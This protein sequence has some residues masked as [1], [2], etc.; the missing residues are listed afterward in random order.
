MKKI[1]F[2]LFLLI[3]L[4]TSS[5]GLSSFLLEGN[6]ITKEIDI[7]KNYN[8]LIE[9]Y[10]NNE[11]EP[12]AKFD[13]LEEA[14]NNANLYASVNTEV[15]VY[16]KPGLNEVNVLEVDQNIT[17]NDNVN[18][19][20][21]F[22]DKKRV[23]E[24]IDIIAGFSNKF[25]DQDANLVNSNRKILLNLKNGADLLVDKGANLYLGGE[26]KTKGVSNRYCEILLSKDSS[27]TVNG[28]FY[29]YGYVKEENTGE[30]TGIDNEYD[31][32]RFIHITNGGT[33]YTPFALYDFVESGGTLTEMSDNGVCPVNII[34]MPSMQTYTRIDYGSELI[35]SC[36]VT[37]AGQTLSRDATIISSSDKEPSLF[38][39]KSGYI[40]IEHT[41]LNKNGYT[42]NDNSPTYFYVN[43]NI[44]LGYLK[45]T[46]AGYGIDTRTCFL[47]ISNKFKIY[48]LS[49]SYFEMSYN[50]KF[51][52]GSLL[53]I[54]DNAELI[55]NADLIFL[56]KDSLNG[57]ANAGYIANQDGAL[58]Q[59]AGKITINE[60]GKIGANI[61]NSS[62]DDKAIIDF[63]NLSS[64]SG[65]TVDC[66]NGSKFVRISITSD[67]LFLNE[68]GE[69]VKKQ[70]LYG[71]NY[72][73]SHN[74]EGYFW[75]GSAY[76]IL[77][78][79]ITVKD[80]Y[81]INIGQFSL[82]T[83]PNADGSDATLLADSQSKSGTFDIA[84]GNYFRIDS[85]RRNKDIYFENRIDSFSSNFWFKITSNVNVIIVPNKG[86]NLSLITQ[87]A[88]GAS[89]AKY[90]VEESINDNEFETIS[91]ITAN[92]IV[93]IIEGSKVRVT[94]TNPGTAKTVKDKFYFGKG[95][96]NKAG[97]TFDLDN[98][99]T[100][101][102]QVKDLLES[103]GIQLL[104]IM[105][106]L[107]NYE[108]VMDS[109]YTILMTR[110]NLVPGGCFAKG[111]K[112]LM[113]DGSYKN[114]ED[115]KVG[116]YIKTFN[117]DIGA[118]ED[119]FITYI[120][121]HSKNIYKVLKL[122]F[123]GAY[124][125]EVLYAHGFMNANTRLYEEISYNNV[126]S[127]LGERYL[128]VEKDKL[129]TRKLVSFE[130]Y[131]KFT[132]CYSL[133]SAYNLNHIANGAL[134]IS[135]DIEGLYNYFELDQ[136]Y[137][138]DSIKKEEDL[139]KYGLLDYSAVSY[140]M[141]KEIYDLFNVKYLS[142]A[143]GKG[144]ITIEKMEEYINKFA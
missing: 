43:G 112:I 89:S 117:H 106:D 17:L 11:S 23:E 67:G 10:R 116:D 54:A 85:S 94:C 35:A 51:L 90:K 78:L 86:V 70:F 113:S 97:P 75:N 126:E 139:K 108:W 107:K 83:S 48:L 64:Q 52:P 37:V 91:E 6:K 33:V 26:F 47:P 102:Q 45:I 129:V 62:L 25:G 59:N 123:E 49:N 14:V 58:L 21:P 105:D 99:E 9:N 8:A 4:I 68:S 18:L 103:N 79:N 36:A 77:K 46:V 31:K 20:L 29:C 121:Y 65:L 19:F 110:K 41:R 42:T 142:V 71:T 15:N 127:K 95:F 22:V 141:S 128:F 50:V 38:Y 93:S 24:D 81:E 111:T 73:A 30:S 87:S 125:I 55:I 120:P 92:G 72:T 5:I 2:F 133:A 69:I 140:F 27:I 82:Y 76:E 119:Q 136:N 101:E 115:I 84:S 16:I 3:S 98:S 28:T 131:D 143:I 39:L 134:C 32:N 13:S 138:Y 109:G 144:M 34:D 63:K 80:L 96:L 53:S 137:K 60:S 74:E 12:Y 66:L 44:S 7:D 124:N 130:I 104:K 135:D 118:I 57:I 61:L 88:S 100:R 1:I 40:G 122:K 132:E 114:I 56:P